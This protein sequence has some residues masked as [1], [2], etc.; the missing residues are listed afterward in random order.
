VRLFLLV[1]RAHTC[2][3]PN[4][5]V[6][7][8][9]RSLG[10]WHRRASVDALPTIHLHPRRALFLPL[11]AR[12]LAAKPLKPVKRKCPLPRRN[13]KNISDCREREGVGGWADACPRS[14]SRVC[15]PLG[16][17]EGIGGCLPYSN[18]PSS[19]AC[20]ISPPGG[21]GFGGSPP[22]PEKRKCPLPRGNLKN[23]S[24]RRQREGVGGG[25]TLA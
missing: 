24:V 18:P 11:E 5:R 25:Q 16:L 17:R 4:Y 15:L 3:H 9:H 8:P 12:V 1:G 13:L 7:P 10:R 23:I 14:D 19:T 6:C 2:L 22:K 20:I 21:E